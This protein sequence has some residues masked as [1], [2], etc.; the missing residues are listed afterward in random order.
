MSVLDNRLRHHR[1]ELDERRRFLAGLE[2]LAARIAEA[3]L[4]LPGV[5]GVSVQVAKRPESMQPIEAAAVR[6]NRT[7][8]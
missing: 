8:A 6:I 2:T 4:K 5:A 1:W 7:R 3:V